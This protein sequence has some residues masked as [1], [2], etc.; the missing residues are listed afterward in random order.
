VEL[1]YYKQHR[2]S[3]DQQVMAATSKCSPLLKRA[4]NDADKATLQTVLLSMCESSSECLAA[5][6]E[7]LLVAQSN[8]KRRGEHDGGA[9]N[10]KP[11]P[12]RRKALERKSDDTDLTSR[13]ETCATCLKR[14]DI[15]AN[16]DNSCRTHPGKDDWNWTCQGPAD[17]SQIDLK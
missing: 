1:L 3:T 15:T 4:I 13:Y 16:T 5:A 10:L 17:L 8:L 2:L 11:N 12:K 7:R 6:S 9:E 14:F